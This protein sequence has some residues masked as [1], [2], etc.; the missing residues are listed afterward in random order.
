ML[1]EQIDSEL[2]GLKMCNDILFQSISIHSKNKFQLTLV[3]A[4]LL[5]TNPK[6]KLA[7]L[8]RKNENLLKLMAI[9]DTVI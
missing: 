4:K 3:I 6:K 8:S 5:C 9:G 2:T 1:D 7:P